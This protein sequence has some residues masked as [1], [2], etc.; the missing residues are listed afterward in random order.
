MDMG[1]KLKSYI[2]A[3]REMLEGGEALENVPE[4]KKELLSEIEF[5]QH[6]RF[7]HLIVMFLF[8]VLTMAV[9]MVFIFAPTI[10]MAILFVALL[11]LL[12]PYI[13]HYFVL[14]NGVQTL[15]V[16]YEEIVR[17]T[18]TADIRCIPEEYGIKIPEIKKG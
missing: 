9:F 4:I 3:L 15:Y 5:W 13:K 14:E 8:A 12:V 7:V 2:R 6:E 17:R 10:P 1:S 16:M 18:T 11:V